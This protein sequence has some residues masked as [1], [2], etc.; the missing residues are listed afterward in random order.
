MPITLDVSRAPLFVV[1]ATGALT[2]EEYAAQLVAWNEQILKPGKP[3][4]F[5]YDGT[6]VRKMT[7]A[8]RELQSDWINDHRATIKRLNR[9]CGFVIDS[10][11]T[12]GPLRAVH[13]LS[14]P[15]YP[16]AIFAKR[17]D[18]LDWCRKQL[19]TQPGF[20]TRFRILRQELAA[21]QTTLVAEGLR[22]TDAAI[23]LWETGRRLPSSRMLFKIIAVFVRLGAS[24]E[25]IEQLRSAWLADRDDRR[26]PQS[27]VSRSNVAE[28]VE[29][30]PDENLGSG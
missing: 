4:A 5:V 23:S 12:R 27:H 9:G 10:A 1:T 7:C 21:K 25:D 20:G 2:D 24:S 28:R 19:A 11:V 26:G 17:D 22:C 14:P 3:Y 13:W 6:A 15:P 8:Q 30:F 29:S 18:A 16:Y